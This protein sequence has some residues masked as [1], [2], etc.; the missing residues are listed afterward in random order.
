M[1]ISWMDRYKSL[2][3]RH[4]KLQSKYYRLKAKL[5]ADVNLTEPNIISKKR[6]LEV[7]AIL[8]NCQAKNIKLREKIEEM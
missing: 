6:Y 7:L 4:L 8:R 3:V 1:K 2:R 5:L